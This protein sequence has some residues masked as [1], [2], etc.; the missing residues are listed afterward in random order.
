MYRGRLRQTAMGRCPC[1]AT[2]VKLWENKGVCEKA[3]RESGGTLVDLPRMPRPPSCQFSISQNMRRLPREDRGR[4]NAEEYPAPCPAQQ[5]LTS[6]IPPTTRHQDII[7]VLQGRSHQP[8]TTSSQS[9]RREGK[10]ENPP[11]RHP[12]SRSEL[13]KL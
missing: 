10:T 9:C 4:S 2:H 8:I 3:R 5:A 12:G 11:P 7:Q 1:R 6:Q 13:P